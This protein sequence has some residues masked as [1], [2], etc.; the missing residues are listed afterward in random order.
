MASGVLAAV[1]A[2]TATSAL[3]AQTTVPTPESVIGFAPC[4]DYKLA[5]YEV[6]TDYFRKL[7]AASD[8]MQL[9]EIGKTAEGRTQILTVISSEE[10]LR[11]LTKYKQIARMLAL[12][13]DENNRP[14][15][16][17]RA[18]QLARDGKAVIWIDFGL[19]A[20]EVA[21]AQTAPWMAWKAVTEETD[22]MKEIRDKVIFVG[23]WPSTGRDSRNSFGR[24]WNSR[25]M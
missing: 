15:T 2:L 10:N 25:R 12:N 7:D 21:H 14:L 8:R 6:I 1:L 17:E 19:H 18:R 3:P 9:F 20:T 24:S 16:D 5:T 11:N 22:E 4:S 13:R 23:H